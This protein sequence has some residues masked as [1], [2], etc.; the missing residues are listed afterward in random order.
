MLHPKNINIYISLFI[1]SL[2]AFYN[3][4]DNAFL[5]DDFPMLVGNLSIGS[6]DFLQFAPSAT[7][8]L[9]F[10]PVTHI[11]NLITFLLF[12]SN[13][14]GYHAVNLLLFVSAGF[15]FFLLIARIFFNPW[16][17]FCSAVVFVIHPINGVCVNYKNATG[18][19]FLVL[20]LGLA[21]WHAVLDVQKNSWNEKILS[22][23]W[24]SLAVFCHEI[25]LAF[26]LYLAAL[27]FAS[28]RFSFR[29]IIRTCIPSAIILVIYFLFRLHFAS[30]GTTIL[31]QAQAISSST[32]L[33]L[34]DIS[35]M[36]F[37]YLTKIIFMRD[38]VLMWDVPAVH[39]NVLFWIA[40]LL[41]FVIGWTA[42]IIYLR[43]RN[44]LATLG[45][46]WFVIGFLPVFFA[47]FS[48][49]WFGIIV[50]PFWLIMSSLGFFIF[51]ASV[52]FQLCQNYL[53]ALIIGFVLVI[54]VFIIPATWRYNDLW[55]NAIAYSEYWI[56]ISPRNFFPRFWLAYSLMEEKDYFRAQQILQ[57]LV[58]RGLRYEW[59]YGNLGVSEY[60]L[61]RYVQ[62][63]AALSNALSYNPRRAD[64]HYYLGMV[65]LAQ[66]DDQR[67]EKA[68]ETALY[69]SPEIV[70]AKL[71]LE[72]IRARRADH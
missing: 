23:V 46:F 51:V 43:R 9:Y 70:D 39:G 27:L 67:A 38:I 69:F 28:G 68:F 36:V 11:L 19:P 54:T 21:L 18:D 2:V 3:S 58:D 63:Q 48:R 57:D 12:G 42:A 24:L 6:T 29:D 52:L 10:R 34:A 5:M 33:L 20:A 32:A 61:R 22:A 31:A 44:P 40:G 71:Q 7:T 16:V 60:H 55:G 49:P 66:G 4:F 53:K 41:S 25:A 1:V 65:F 72:S 30:L 37:W 8:Q 62:A 50:Q 14:L 56:K 64:T 26:P 35:Q 45:L 15:V 13:P 59:T 17:A 47:C